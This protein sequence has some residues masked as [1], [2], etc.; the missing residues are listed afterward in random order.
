MPELLQYGRP[1]LVLDLPTLANI[2]LGLVDNWNHSDIRK[3]NPGLAPFLPDA[4]IIIILPEGWPGVISVIA[5]SL[6]EANP[7]FK[8]IVGTGP[9]ITLPLAAGRV[10]NA[11]NPVDILANTNYTLAVWLYEQVRQNRQLGLGDLINPAG[12]QVSPTA[13]SIYSAI[14][15][16]NKTIAANIS[17]ISSLINGLGADSWPMV[18]FHQFMVH[19]TT[20]ADCLKAQSLADWIFWTQTD[21]TAFIL[22][23]EYVSDCLL[24]TV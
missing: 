16:F 1:K 18:A 23:N 15:D 7:E 20:M 2:M 19:Q 22:A 10:I 13:N 6:S 3:L 8:S 21:E 5:Q 12:N 9:N 14:N 17:H 11:S 24:D 4:E